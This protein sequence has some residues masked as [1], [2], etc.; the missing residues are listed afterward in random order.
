MAVLY[1]EEG[2]FEEYLFLPSNLNLVMMDTEII[3]KSSV[4]LSVVCMGDA[5][6]IPLEA[7]ACMRNGATQS[8]GSEK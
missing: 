2:V 6:A 1:T 7:R 8:Y 4:R 5:L 3:A